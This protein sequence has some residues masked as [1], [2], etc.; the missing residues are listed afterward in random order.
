VDGGGKESVMKKVLLTGGSGFLGRRILVH[1][2]REDFT[3][4]TPHRK[5]CEQFHGLKDH[6]DHGIRGVRCDLERE[7]GGILE[8]MRWFKPDAV[9][10]SAAYYGGIGICKSD[11]VGLFVR[12][13]RMAAN[14]IDVCSRTDS[15]VRF[16]CIGSACGYPNYL[17]GNLSERDWWKG[18]L[19]PSVEAYG[20]TKK[21]Q[22]V[23]A[24]VLEKARGVAYQVPIL[25]NLYGEYDVFQEARSHVVAALIK[26]FADA[27]LADDKRI[28]GRR[29]V[30]HCWGTGAPVREFLYVDDAAGAIVMLLKSDLRG[31]V[32]IGTGTG[33][34]IKDLATMIAHRVGFDGHIEW[35]TDKPDGAMHKVLDVTR[36]RRELGWIHRYCLGDGIAK[37]VKWYMSHKEEAD[38]RK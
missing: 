27:K 5:G 16:M 12:N 35:D 15:I 29:R 6:I 3:V 11:P 36:V 28:T 18:P 33:T 26:K 13:T 31:L 23:G 21:I 38:Q 9:I 24:R 2:L 37:T 1:L 34:S 10:H 22:E 8:I 25:T 4:L 30:V 19:H 14:L 7:N 32:N 17:Q 20:F